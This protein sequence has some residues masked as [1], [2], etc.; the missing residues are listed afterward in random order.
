MV[1]TNATEVR[2]EPSGKTANV[3]PGTTLTDA[4]A[5]AGVTL[6]APCGGAGLCR[7]CRV[8]AQGE[9]SPLDPAER[10]LLT[11][12]EI[13]TGARLACRARVSGPVTVWRRRPTAASAAAIGRPGVE[14]LDWAGLSPA[15]AFDVGTT[16][17][18][19]GLVDLR[20]GDIV[21][22]LA[23]A[24]PQREWGADVMSRI[25]SAQAGALEDMRRAVTEALAGMARDLLESARA[26]TGEDA[27]EGSW[28]QGPVDAA[29]VGNPAMLHILA[30]VDPGPLGTAPY[31]AA[32]L[33]EREIEESE[34]SLP[35]G[36]RATTLPAIGPHVGADAVADALAARLVGKEEPVLLV[37]LGTNAEALLWDGSGTLWATSAAAGPAFEG[38][39]LSSGMPATEGAIEGVT[40][41][42][43]GFDLSVIGGGRPRGFCGSGILELMALMLEE[44]TME[45]SGRLLSAPE[46][47]DGLMLT[48]QD[49]RSVQLAKGAVTAALDVLLEK[50][51]IGAED[52]T[53][54]FVAGAFGRRLSA[55]TLVR[56]GIIHPEWGARVRFLGDAALS[57]AARWLADPGAREE[58]T[59]IRERARLVD[60][61]RDESFQKR[62][63]G[64]L[65]F[66]WPGR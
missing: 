6:Q 63:M 44:G 35:S 33:D 17:L 5:A 45:E 59:R 50:A 10:S 64:A 31:E 13:A 22:T 29:L 57:G 36:S 14:P 27:A 60:L 15:L 53:R 43:S 19:A 28:A 42:S 32:F 7:G 25:S 24:N 65:D 52:L 41:G 47:P 49:V 16:S 39:G 54:V 1:E 18:V 46:L 3:P 55:Q 66:V 30:A 48:Q 56:L 62:F 23:A 20:S 51:D 11:A 9:L 58:A 26:C 38:G 2:F 37:D 8:F 4:A 40:Q 34:L 61:A 12:E 21:R